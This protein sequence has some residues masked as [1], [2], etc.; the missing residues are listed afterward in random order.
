[1]YSSMG[2]YVQFVNQIDPFNRETKEVR[3]V[4]EWLSDVEV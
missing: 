1:M 4:E 3:P 2:E